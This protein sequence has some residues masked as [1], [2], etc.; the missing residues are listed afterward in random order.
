MSDQLSTFAAVFAA[1]YAAHQV[2]DHWVQTQ[3]QA[4]RKGLPGRAGRL[5]C[6]AHVATY[7]ATAFVALAL[8]N[9]IVGLP[10]RPPTMIAGL[11]ISAVT[12][13][14]ADRR[15]PLRRMVH[16]LRK[17]PAWIERGGGLYAMDQSWHVGWLFIASLVVAA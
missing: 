4:V 2:G 10:F 14:I 8:L 17:N 11:A 16:A 15:E 6:T 5:A 3:D 7:T 12:H 9:T 13:Y 1:L